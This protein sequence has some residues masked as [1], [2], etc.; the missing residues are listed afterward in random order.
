MADH[1]VRQ[2]WT[3]ARAEGK[4]REPC[5]PPGAAPWAWLTLAL[6]QSQ[7]ASGPAG[8]AAQE[9]GSGLR[10]DQFILSCRVLHLP[11]S[12]FRPQCAQAELS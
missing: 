9:R 10:P 2:S 8:R 5:I 4:P 12:T 11:R 3:P 1:A 6:V 7:P